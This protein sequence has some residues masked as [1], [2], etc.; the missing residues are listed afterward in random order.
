MALRVIA[1][2]VGGRKLVAPK[3]VTR[4]TQD[5]V[6]E[7][8]FSSLGDVV[9]DAVVLDLYAGSGALA[10]EALSRGAAQAVLV[11]PDRAAAVAIEANLE[12]TGFAPVAS[13]LRR[14]AAQY[15]G[16]GAPGGPFDLVVLDPP[17]DTPSGEV[18]ELLV[19]LAASGALRN[20][21]TVVVE[22]P[23]G[24]DPVPLPQ[25][26]DVRRERTYG[27]TLLLIVSV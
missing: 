23:A 11:D 26:W 15:V 18:A 27:D 17:Y 8:L 5:R 19:A 7:A 9:V 25:G 20:G 13:V 14:P 21:A 2:S 12:T 22:R 6:K 4:P 10:I 3:G 1:G 16:G 24:G